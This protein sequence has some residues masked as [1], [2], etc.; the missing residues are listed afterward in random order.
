M[1]P[2]FKIS[3]H[4][5]EMGTPFKDAVCYGVYIEVGDEATAEWFQDQD[6]EGNG[7]TVLALIDSLCRAELKEDRKKYQ[8]EAEADNAWVYGRDKEAMD[9]F[10]QKFKAVTKTEAGVQQL[11][12]KAS[13]KL[14][15]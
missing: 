6:L 7:Y 12:N 9:R 13:K 1:K 2:K 3:P 5:Y 14:L 8:M 15:E 10:V 11:I 4:E